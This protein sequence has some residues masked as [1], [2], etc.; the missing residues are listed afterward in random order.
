MDNDNRPMKVVYTIVERQPGKSFWVRLG[1]AFANRDG[2]WNIHLD[3]VPTNG[4]LQ[5]RDPEPAE[6]RGPRGSRP[7]HTT[8]EGRI[9]AG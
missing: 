8:D 6:D 3:A 2:S 9:A 5:L 7:F 4:K 1:A